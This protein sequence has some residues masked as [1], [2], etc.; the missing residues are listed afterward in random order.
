MESLQHIT[1]ISFYPCYLVGELLF[2]VESLQHITVISFYP[3]YLVRELLF[4]VE[5]LQPYPIA[6]LYP[7]F[8]AARTTRVGGIILVSSVMVF[9][10]LTC[11]QNSMISL[12]RSRSSV[13]SSIGKLIS[14]SACGNQEIATRAPVC[15][16][17]QTGESPVQSHVKLCS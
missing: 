10:C 12:F 5:S 9:H 16:A 15:A 8:G 2:S 6:K 1:V 4:S 11:L 17:Y 3:C 14:R 7:N 13:L